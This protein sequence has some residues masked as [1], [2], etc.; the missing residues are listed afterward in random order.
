MKKNRNL[1][2]VTFVVGAGYVLFH[3]LH[4]KEIL[5]KEQKQIRKLDQLLRI[6]NQMILESCK[7]KRIHQKLEERNLSSA[8]IYGMGDMGEHIME[9]ALLHSSIKLLYGI[10]QRAGELKMAIPVYTLEEA[11]QKEKP[12]VVILT[13][14]TENDGLKNEIE[15]VMSCKV[16]TL[17]ELLYE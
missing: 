1:L 17:G 13:T 6:A 16:I 9:D 12:E 4:L 15:K 2:R 8:A 7:G 5:R 14:Y 11:A 10:D 3:Y